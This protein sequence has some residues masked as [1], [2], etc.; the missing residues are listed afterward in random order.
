MNNSQDAIDFI[1]ETEFPF[2][3]LYFK[4][5]RVAIC[6]I[7]ENPGSDPATAL[8]EF[9]QALKRVTANGAYY[10]NAIEKSKGDK[11]A[12]RFDFRIEN[13]E[14]TTNPRTTTVNRSLPMDYQS[15]EKQIENQL[16]I[17]QS[18]ERIEKKLDVILN[19]LELMAD[20]DKGNDN[21]IIPLIKSVLMSSISKAATGAKSFV[22]SASNSSF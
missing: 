8:W 12:T 19:V 21:E 1:Q 20:D 9:E 7:A 6:D 4:G 14:Q 17:K 13:S 22:P 15:L 5:S 11:G 2:W 3:K 16:L 18:Q 10:V